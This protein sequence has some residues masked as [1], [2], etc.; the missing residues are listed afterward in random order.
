LLIRYL[1]LEYSS[2]KNEDYDFEAAL[3][4]NIAK[5]TLQR[6][7]Y[8]C[9]VYVCI[10]AYIYCTLKPKFTVDLSLAEVELARQRLL[11][12]ILPDDHKTTTSTKKSNIVFPP[13][14]SPDET[15]K[16]LLNSCPTS[17]NTFYYPIEDFNIEE[18]IYSG[19]LTEVIKASHRDIGT[20][21][22]SCNSIMN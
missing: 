3:A 13:P 4:L 17:I 19:P 11:L 15:Y 10:Y 18:A 22:S 16:E 12:W 8:D 2:Q 9:G 6:N 14:L 5:I 7:S 21:I 1:R 20:N